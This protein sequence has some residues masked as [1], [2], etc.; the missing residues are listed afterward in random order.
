MHTVPFGGAQAYNKRWYPGN[1]SNAGFPWKCDRFPHG[2]AAATYF[3]QINLHVIP[4]KQSIGA[5]VL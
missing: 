3:M 2:Y 4:V 5:A 1:P